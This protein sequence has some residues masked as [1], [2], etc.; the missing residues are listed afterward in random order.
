MTLMRVAFGMITVH[1]LDPLQAKGQVNK[2][3]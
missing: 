3:D 2:I 1:E